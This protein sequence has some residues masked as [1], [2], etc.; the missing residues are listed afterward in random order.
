MPTT[1]A[2]LANRLIVGAAN[3]S[4]V[5]GVALVVGGA[6]SARLSVGVVSAGNS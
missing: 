3:S 6:V 1:K 2:G 5:V 4:R